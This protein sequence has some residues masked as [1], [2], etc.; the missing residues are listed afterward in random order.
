M[1]VQLT[2]KVRTMNAIA[3]AKQVIMS[4][5]ASLFIILLLLDDE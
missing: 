5:A 1:N 4:E 3:P 2:T